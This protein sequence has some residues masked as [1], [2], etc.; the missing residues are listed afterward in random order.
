MNAQSPRWWF[1][2]N[3][4]VRLIFAPALVFIAT[5]VNHNYQTDFWH[6]LARGQ[7]ITER[8]ALV[9]SDLYTFTVPD[10][11]FQ[12]ANWLSQVLYY[13]LFSLG[14]LDLVQFVNSLTLAA[15]MGLVIAM[16]WRKSGSALISGALG[17]FA[18]LGMWQL[19]IIRPQTFSLLLFVLVFAALE[20]A[21][22]RPRWLLLPP[23]F[24]ALWAN[25]HGGF[26]IG[27]ILVG[28]Y[29]LASACEGW[30][31]ESWTFLRSARFL[32]F[33]ASLVACVFAT[34]VNPYGWKVYEYVGVTSSIP[35]SRRIDE[36]LP[37]G[38]DQL[39]GKIWVLSVLGMLVLFAL[40]WRRPNLR[41]VC[42][43]L[44][45]LPLACSSVRMVSWWLLICTP[46][47][48]RLLVGALPTRWT[49]PAESEKPTVGAAV[50]VV[51]ILIVCAASLPWFDASNPALV[52]T[53][54]NH[55]TEDD[56]AEVAAQLRERPG[57]GRIFSR[58]E[59]GEYFGWALAPR[60]K[61]FMDGRLEIFPDAVWADFSAV[62]RGRADWEAILARYEVDCLLLDQ[63][64]FHSDLLP[65]VERSPNWVRAA[66]SG[67]AVLFVRAPSDRIGSRS[68]SSIP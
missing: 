65:L 18:F 5:S 25:M 44:C 52:L 48:A 40:P 1:P 60:Y 17:V 39:V 46:I 67:D 34:L 20:G 43:V 19:L 9:D 28:C 50:S 47:A 64:G 29:V 6:H 58:F 37:P 36:W 57:D 54:R 10:K 32:S 55:R 14:G 41:E 11:P 30:W 27:L 56:L 21:I 2:T 53:H 7:A 35:S 38:M 63:S 66:E 42:L 49:A 24:M 45:F 12:D 23:V 31:S 16:S 51:A 61:V 4:W 68:L 13:R 26:P 8:G 59:W 62:T 15:V 22:R 33:L 3:N